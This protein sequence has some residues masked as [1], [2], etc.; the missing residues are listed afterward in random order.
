MNEPAGFQVTV[1]CGDPHRQ[2]RFWAGALGYEVERHEGRI[3]ELLD[4]G[5]ATPADVLEVEG[6]LSWRT[7][8]AI[9]RPSGGGERSGAFRLLFLQVPEPKTV[10]NR[11]HLD[12]TVTG[13]PGGSREAVEAEVARLRGLGAS[14]LYRIDSREGFHVTMADPEGNEFC[15]Q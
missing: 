7:A 10:K 6:R 11:W 1:D 5:V 4:A 13:G 9:R 15:V 3:R 8:A 12:L 2:S 14:E